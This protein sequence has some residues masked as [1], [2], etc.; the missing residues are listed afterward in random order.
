MSSAS[1]GKSGIPD[2]RDGDAS[3]TS[4]TPAGSGDTRQDMLAELMRK[5][6][7]RQLRRTQRDGD[8]E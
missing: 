1:F 3:R 6:S 8:V 4:L 2:S 5:A 7:A